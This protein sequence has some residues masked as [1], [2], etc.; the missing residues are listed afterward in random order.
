MAE[1]KRALGLT[2]AT[3]C[4]IGIILGAGI[5]ALI[6]KAAGMAGNATWLSF[7][8]AA[9]V[10][11]LSGLSYAEL[12]SVFP[13]AGAEYEYSRHA[14]GK[15]IAFIVGW[16]IALSGIIGGTTVALGFGGYFEGMFGTPVLLTAVAL[17]V[18][19]SLVIAYGVKEA[20]WFAMVGT[21]FEAGGLLI[22]ILIALP[23]FGSVDYLEVPSFDGVFAAAALVFFAYIG[24]EEMTR[25]AEEVRKPE[26]N[27][28]RALMIAIAVTTVFYILVAISAVSV[29]DYD[30]LAAS[31]SPLAEVVSVAWSPEAFFAFS[32]IALFAT[33]NTV[34][35][36]LMAA[37]RIIYGMADSGALPQIVSY[38][39]PSRRTPWVAIG[40]AGALALAFFMVGEIEKIANLT[41]FTVF[42]TFVVINAA[43]IKLRYDKRDMKRPFKVPINIGWFPV[44][45]LLAII[46]TLFMMANVGW[47]A[48]VYGVILIVLGIIAYYVIDKFTHKG[49][50][51]KRMHPPRKKEVKI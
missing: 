49:V 8:I 26:K 39:N 27:M 48:V 20:A 1:L 28:P 18:L 9:I 44:L 33:G 31:N 21:L 23:Y 46:T 47:E 17:V 13:K 14:F 16:M 5:Y 29:V 35:L 2:E 38:V 11:G 6:G 34:L 51:I 40:I 24:F 42:A 43:L 37:S 12:S 7:V 41:N 36:I 30:M 19:L 22:V 3:I 32:I 15:K 45:P 4:G 50:R 25:M 10:A